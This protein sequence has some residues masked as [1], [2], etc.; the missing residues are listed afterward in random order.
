MVHFH[1][2][3]NITLLPIFCKR[4]V[5]FLAVIFQHCNKKNVI[6]AVEQCTSCKK[7][8]TVALIFFFSKCISDVPIRERNNFAYWTASKQYFSDMIETCQGKIHTTKRRPNSARIFGRE[9][10]E[11]IFFTWV[12][13]KIL[14]SPPVRYYVIN[15]NIY[16]KVECRKKRS[17][18]RG[19]GLHF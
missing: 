1:H 18:H 17:F 19:R 3:W 8:S 12:G 6:A 5:I 9:K 14:E 16:E 4:N 7:K 11:N 2:N 13:P 10:K 15:P